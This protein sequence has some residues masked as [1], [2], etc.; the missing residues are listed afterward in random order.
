MMVS[1]AMNR[2][3]AKIYRLSET[4]Y[5]TSQTRYDVFRMLIPESRG[6]I[7]LSRIIV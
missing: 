7:N 6:L 2:D 3:Y 4:D 1:L 5:G